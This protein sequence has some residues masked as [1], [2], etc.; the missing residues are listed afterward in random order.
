MDLTRDI[1]IGRVMHQ[2]DEKFKQKGMTDRYYYNLE[3]QSL[4]SRATNDFVEED[5]ESEEEEEEEV[6]LQAF[7]TTLHAM[8]LF[9]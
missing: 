9:V 4:E 8:T 3:V 7:M 1:C 6:R 2:A 5:D